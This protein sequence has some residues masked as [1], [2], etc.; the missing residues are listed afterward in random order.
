MPASS[1][2]GGVYLGN[3]CGI[4]VANRGGRQAVLAKTII[5]ATPRAMVADNDLA[6][7]MV[8]EALSKSKFWPKTCILVTEEMMK[9]I[10]GLEQPD[11][12]SKQGHGF[13]RFRSK[14]APA[15]VLAG[16]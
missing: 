11:G 13:R 3:P 7:G 16:C 5:D 4:V 1:S 12:L 10:T 6:L 15:I 9:K 2:S 14:G 8:V